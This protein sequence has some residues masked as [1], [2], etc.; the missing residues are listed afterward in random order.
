M[1][2]RCV[3]TVSNGVCCHVHKG[4]PHAVLLLFLMVFVVMFTKGVLS[5]VVTVSNG[6][7]CHVH[8]GC[9]QVVLLLFLMVFVVMF[10]KGVLK[11]CCYCF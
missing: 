10:T 3:V 9:P 4:C 7:C 11:L 1:S 8:K 2:S 5:C 6:V